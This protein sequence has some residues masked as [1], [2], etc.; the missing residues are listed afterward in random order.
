MVPDVTD[1]NHFLENP[2]MYPKWN[3][4]SKITFNQIYKWACD[5]THTEW[6]QYWGPAL[7]PFPRIMTERE[8]SGFKNGKQ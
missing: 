4:P 6:P 8:F 7:F 2:T 5:E 3:Q 1:W